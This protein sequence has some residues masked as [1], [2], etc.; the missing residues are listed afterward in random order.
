LGY[1]DNF[2][3]P[4]NFDPL[5]S[6]A[7]YIPNGNPTGYV[8]SWHFTVQQELAKDLVLDMGYVGNRGVHLMI[9][10]DYNQAVPNQPGQNLSL[11]ARR[12]IPNFAYIEVAF[13]AGNS[14]YNGFQ[15]KLEKRFARGFYLLNSFTWSKALDDAPGHLEAYNGDQT[16]V[17]YA[18]IANDK[19]YSNYNQPLNDTTSLIWELPVGRN[20]R[21]LTGA[22]GLLEGIL[23]GWQ[24]TAINTATSGLPIN[25]TYSPTSQFQVSTAPNYRPNVTC[26]PVTPEG[27]RTTSN[28]LNKAC[29]AAP[30]D[31]SHP[32]GNA[33]RNS[34]KGYPFYQLDLGL[35]KQFGL[36]SENARLE[37]RAEA[38]N[39][40]NQ[41]NFQ[42][43]NSNISSSGFGSI[44]SAFPARQ[45]QFAAKILF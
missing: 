10:A 4:A 3:S 25:L 32:W 20:H 30:T 37:F 19:G 36:W 43:P 15:M 2:A 28:Y 34:V 39:L 12:P 17:N 18:D 5:R 22:S 35:H 16:R 26:N 24:L 1:P 23:G 41:T 33:S 31:P 44:T 13:G 7:R 8:E 21:F 9:L 29:V 27:Q 14:S 11:Q 42:A 38:F 6:Q 40:L 45:V